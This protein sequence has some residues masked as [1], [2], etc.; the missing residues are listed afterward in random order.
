M[1]IKTIAYCPDAAFHGFLHGWYGI[2]ASPSLSYMHRNKFLFMA[3]ISAAILAAPRLASAHEHQTF[4]IGGKTYVFTIG[5]LNEPVAVDDKSGIDIEIALIENGKEAPVTGLEAT[6]K[7]EIIAGPAKRTFDLSPVYGK[8]GGYK[9]VFFPTI[10]TTYTYRIF[11]T[12]EGTA[13]DVSFACNPAGH[14]IS[15]DWKGSEPLSAGVARIA[16]SGSFGC[17]SGKAELGFP[18]P[19][20]SLAQMHQDTDRNDLNWG[21]I[22]TF[23]GVIGCLLGLLA[24]K[25]HF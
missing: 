6:L 17:P 21:L 9:A 14:A 12:I 16:K 23:I 10:Q 13:V 22:G 18:E 8:P 2:F 3:M 7:A 19:S 1:E 24:L 5:S 20:M 25:K 4:E 15:E 11:G